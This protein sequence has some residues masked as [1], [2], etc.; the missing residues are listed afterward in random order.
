MSD[1]Y[2]FFVVMLRS[3]VPMVPIFICIAGLTD[4]VI[5]RLL[6]VYKIEE[7]DFYQQQYAFASIAMSAIAN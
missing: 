7:A 2:A 6:R 5:V 1:D 4:V 3:F